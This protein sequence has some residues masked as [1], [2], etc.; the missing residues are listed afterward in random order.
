M[1]WHFFKLRP[2]FCRTSCFVSASLW[3]A[4]CIGDSN[5]MGKFPCLMSDRQFSR[6]KRTVSLPAWLRPGK[7]ILCFAI[8]PFMLMCKSSSPSTVH[9]KSKSLMG[10]RQGF[11]VRPFC[12]FFSAVWNSSSIELSHP[13]HDVLVRLLAAG[14]EYV[15]LASV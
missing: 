5:P 3:C 9:V 14:R 8:A 12:P 2:R 1:V 4:E 11:P 7:L 13:F 15:V 6:S 10:S